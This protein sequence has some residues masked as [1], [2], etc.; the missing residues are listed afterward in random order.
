MSTLEATVNMVEKLSDE[1][2]I[3]VQ[4]LANQL[5]LWQNISESPNTVL[6]KEQFLQELEESRIQSREGRTKNASQAVKEMRKRYGL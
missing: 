4:N 5:L 6:T 1:N 2:L 3:I